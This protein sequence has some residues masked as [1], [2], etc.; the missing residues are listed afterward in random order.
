MSYQ[1]SNQIKGVQGSNFVPLFYTRYIKLYS[2]TDS[3]TES[4]QKDV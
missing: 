1:S 2:V 3:V 4:L